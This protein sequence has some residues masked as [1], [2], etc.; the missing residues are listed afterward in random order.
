MSHVRIFELILKFVKKKFDFI[1][2]LYNNSDLYCIYDVNKQYTQYNKTYKYAQNPKII[3]IHSAMRITE[4]ILFVNLDQS[5]LA[6][7]TLAQCC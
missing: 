5:R 1:L 3:W 6:N 2:L 7:E 4:I